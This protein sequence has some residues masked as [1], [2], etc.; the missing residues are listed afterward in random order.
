MPEISKPRNW[1]RAATAGIA[2]TTLLAAGVAMA[3]PDGGRGGLDRLE[4]RLERLDLDAE[5]RTAAFSVLDEARDARRAQ[6]PE[7]REARSAMRALLDQPDV[8]E[9]QV[10][11]QVEALHALELEKHK[12][13]LRTLL[14]LRELLTD[15]QWQEL[16]PRREKRGQGR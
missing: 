13:K 15:E 3:R 4:N 7:I 12:A 9:P 11:A 8:E 16:R 5:T 1:R 6:R 10:M 14:A 2:A